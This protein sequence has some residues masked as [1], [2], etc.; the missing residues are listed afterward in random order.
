MIPFTTNT[1]VSPV[2]KQNIGY[3]EPFVSE[4][5]ACMCQETPKEA[6]SQSMCF[7]R[8]EQRREKLRMLDLLSAKSNRIENVEPCDDPLYCSEID[9]GKK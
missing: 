9:I 7:S 8:V 3:G 2:S 6:I 1:K 5:V 4:R